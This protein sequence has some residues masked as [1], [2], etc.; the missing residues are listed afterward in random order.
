MRYETPQVE[1]TLSG[2]AGADRMS[3][4][5]DGRFIFTQE[6]LQKWFDEQDAIVTSTDG[7]QYRIVDRHIQPGKFCPQM[8]CNLE[9][10]IP[11][12]I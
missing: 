4:E 3:A 5:Q 11:D 12:E 8:I 2:R 10:I 9:E 7:K 6:T 1:K